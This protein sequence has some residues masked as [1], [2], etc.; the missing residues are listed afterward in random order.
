MTEKKD[1][2]AEGDGHI[3]VTLKRPIEIGGTTITML[4]IREPSVA[5]QLAMDTL[6]GS[7]AEREVGLFANLCV[8]TPA[9]IQKL[10]LADYKRLQEAF[11]SFID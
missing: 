1:Y 5:D 10:K 8:V 11:R 7:D 2:L 4:R 9:D 6:K 3:D